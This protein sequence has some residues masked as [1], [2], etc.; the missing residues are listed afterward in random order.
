MPPTEQVLPILG[1][2]NMVWFGILAPKTLQALA[3]ELQEER[4]LISPHQL[5]HIVGQIKELSVGFAA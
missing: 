4:K 1:K 2:H 5:R 3:V